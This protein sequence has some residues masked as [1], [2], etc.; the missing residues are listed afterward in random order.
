MRRTI[1]TAVAGLLIA[2]LAALSLTVD[3]PFGLPATAVA[4]P[5]PSY[6]G[7]EVTYFLWFGEPLF[8]PAEQISLQQCEALANGGNGYFGF[9]FTPIYDLP[10]LPLPAWKPGGFPPPCALSVT[11]ASG[12]ELLVTGSSGQEFTCNIAADSCTAS[13][14]L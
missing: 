14:G 12:S 3:L 10:E 11:G 8:F 1:R 6:V 5:A 4:E 7:C 9:Y 13:S 2:V